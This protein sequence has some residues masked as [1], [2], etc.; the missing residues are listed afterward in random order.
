MN[1]QINPEQ[2]IILAKQ[3]HIDEL[4]AL[5]S[6]VR[7]IENLGLMVHQLQ[8]ERGA[9]CLYLA[10]CGKRFSHERSEWIAQNVVLGESFK[11]TLKEYLDETTSVNAK[12]LTLFTWILFGLD[13]LESFR[14]QVTLMK[15]SFT[16][17][18][19]SYTRL[20]GS[21]I[22][23]IFEITDTSANGKLSS[24]LVA[25]YNLVRAKE[26]A[27]QERA[28]GSH[29][30]ASGIFNQTHQQRLLELI[31]LQD[32]HSE[33]FVQFA[34]DDLSQAWQMISDNS[35]S[36]LLLK[37]R[38][39]L[40]NS[41]HTQAL[42]TYDSDKWFDICSQRL[43]D[44]FEMQCQLTKYMHQDQETLIKNAKLDLQATTQYLDDI[45]NKLHEKSELD[46][47]FFN[48]AIPI[49]NA[50]SFLNDEKLLAYPIGSF[51]SLLQAQSQQIAKIENELFDTKKVLAERKQIERAKGLLMSTQNISEVEAYK[52]LRSTAMTQNRK[53]IDIAENILMQYK[54]QT[55]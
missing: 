23:I 47:T 13:E 22:S 8:A 30:L 9:S 25:L 1:T 5:S 27:G 54:H 36:H 55:S 46:S 52:W 41:K 42:K 39:K 28:I 10:S 37:F 45:T 53:I 15:V 29:M 50:F 2:T 51:I 18:I 33:G 3:Q 40:G 7:F 32:R 16:D 12:Q 44:M 6:S 34:S 31:E 19:Q 38:K 11:N 21:L 17:C 48:L 24:H 49:E 43:S 26:F 35:N 14:H 20:I 4:Q